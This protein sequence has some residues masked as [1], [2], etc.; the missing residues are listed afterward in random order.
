MIILISDAVMRVKNV[1]IIAI[2]VSAV[3]PRIQ[4]VVT[5]FGLIAAG[6]FRVVFASLVSML[7][8]FPVVN[9][10]ASLRRR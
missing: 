6:A 1:L 9:E 10:F 4:V 7:M 2:L 8:K 3:P 5:F